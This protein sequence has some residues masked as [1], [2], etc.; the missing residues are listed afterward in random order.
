MNR[1]WLALGILLVTGPALAAEL[2]GT[3]TGSVDGP[4][5][6]VEVKYEFKVDGTK[7]TGTTTS[8][9]GMQFMIKNGKVDGTKVA[10]VVD[11]DFGGNAMTFDY[12]GTL[13]GPELK[14]HTEYMG[15]PFDFTLKKAAVKAPAKPETAQ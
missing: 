6:P 15:M 4:N 2:D 9:D 3:W 13:T 12:T 1:K 10:F 14:L 8:P 7:L 5:G 11:L